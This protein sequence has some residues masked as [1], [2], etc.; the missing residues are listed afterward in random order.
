MCVRAVNISKSSYLRVETILTATLNSWLKQVGWFALDFFAMGFG[1]VIFLA[2]TS[3]LL[4]PNIL[5]DHLINTLVFVFLLAWSTLAV[6]CFVLISQP[7]YLT[8]VVVSS[9]IVSGCCT[10]SVQLYYN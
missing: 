2:T 9:F 3:S 1:Q 7:W 10:F 8:L 4:P 6:K 5:Q